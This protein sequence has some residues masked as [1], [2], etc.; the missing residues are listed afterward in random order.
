MGR[1]FHRIMFL[2]VQVQPCGSWKSLL[3]GVKSC[4]VIL[5]SLRTC[6]QSL[7]DRED[8]ELALGFG[9]FI[10]CTWAVTE[11]GHEPK[12][13]LRV[14]RVSI[15]HIKSVPWSFTPSTLILSLVSCIPRSAGMAAASLPALAPGE[16]HP[17]QSHG[18]AFTLSGETRICLM[19]PS[20]V[21]NLFFR[22]MS[23]GRNG[24]GGRQEGSLLPKESRRRGRDAAGGPGSHRRP[25]L[26]IAS[27]ACGTRGQGP[28]LRPAGLRQAAGTRARACG[29]LHRGSR[30]GVSGLTGCALRG[31]LAF[32]GRWHALELPS[33]HFH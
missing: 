23:S 3:G 19:S 29:G 22:L 33:N 12:L 11:P 30:Q 4:L 27:C 5:V 25:P 31:S 28:A 7:G 26:L 6:R 13:R 18:G 16:L 24:G 21:K 10:E 17:L 14:A 2:L 32:C 20:E 9:F 8:R 1:M 15:K